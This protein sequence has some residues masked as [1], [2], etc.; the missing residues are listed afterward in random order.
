MTTDSHNRNEYDEGAGA[1][2]AAPEKAVRV[3]LP[4]HLRAL[5]NVP[6]EVRIAASA[7]VTIGSVLDGIEA[8]YPMLRGAIRDHDAGPRR[9]YVRIFACEEDLSFQPWD[10]PLPGPVADGGEPLLIVGSISGG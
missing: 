2:P 9:P 7:P 5:A 3:V 1:G 4:G 8:R 6:G 10:C